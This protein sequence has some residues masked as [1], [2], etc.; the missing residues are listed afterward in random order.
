MLKIM[1]CILRDA[2]DCNNDL[3]DRPDV[4]P[5]LTNLDLRDLDGDVYGDD[6]REEVLDGDFS[7]IGDFH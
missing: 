6:L 2:H 3:K 7:G 5:N 4:S 1:T